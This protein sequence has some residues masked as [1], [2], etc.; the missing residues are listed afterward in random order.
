[1]RVT[2]K[3][4][5]AGISAVDLPQLFDR[6][7]RS[8]AASHAISHANVAPAS[9]D[10]GRGLGLAIVKRIAE[11]HRGHVQVLSTLGH[12]TTVTL[13]LPAA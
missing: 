3:D 6:L 4:E 1:M 11:L 9:S 2:V 13:E 10:E 8:H 12:G 7:Y 5:G